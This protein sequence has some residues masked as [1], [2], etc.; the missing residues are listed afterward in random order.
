[1]LTV[2]IVM[3][4]WCN[5]PRPVEVRGLEGL[6]VGGVYEATLHVNRGICSLCG[7]KFENLLSKGGATQ[8]GTS[9]KNNATEEKG[10]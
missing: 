6:A 1:M 3:C 7:V 4:P 8:S 10:K 2:T 5:S 9:A